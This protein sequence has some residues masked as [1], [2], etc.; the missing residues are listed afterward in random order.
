[1]SLFVSAAS[2]GEV[3]PRFDGR[4]VGREF[5]KYMSPGYRHFIGAPTVIGI[6]NSGKMLGVISGFAPGRYEISSESSGRT[7]VFQM[8]NTKGDTLLY[9]G[10]QHCTLT[11]SSDGNTIKEYGNAIFISG[12]RGPSLSTD[13]YGTFHRQGK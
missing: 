6:T 11:L 5:F 4:W 9:Q 7:L 8:P 3:D 2:A 12:S 1:M 10:R 13:V